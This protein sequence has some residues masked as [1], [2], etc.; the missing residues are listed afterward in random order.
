MSEYVSMVTGGNYHAWLL[1]AVDRME[2]REW[3]D[4]KLP[5]LD[6]TDIVIGEATMLTR[7]YC[8][9]V[10]AIQH[11]AAK[12]YREVEASNLK[13]HH[14]GYHRDVELFVQPGLRI[15]QELA[16]AQMRLDAGTLRPE[17]QR[18]I[19]MLTQGGKIVGIKSL[20]DL[21]LRAGSLSMIVEV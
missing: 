21:S 7:D 12:K 2:S 1:G 11:E 15:L 3:A 10:M 4:R 6:P 8:Y 14:D 19:I 9:G 20:T 16:G 17:H 13:S 5:S 18:L